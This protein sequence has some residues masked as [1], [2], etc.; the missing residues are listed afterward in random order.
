M[1]RFNAQKKGTLLSETWRL[2][3]LDIELNAQ[4]LK[5]EWKSV[6]QLKAFF[7]IF[8]F[9]GSEGNFL[10]T[11]INFVV[12]L[13]VVLSIFFMKSSVTNEHTNSQKYYA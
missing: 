3:G 5:G 10:Q 1:L 7:I 6:L 9:Y 2:R 8:F 12:F 4:Y 13:F 11:Q